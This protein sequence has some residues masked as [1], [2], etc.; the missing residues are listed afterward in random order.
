MEYAERQTFMKR[1]F[2][3]DC[4][5]S[6]CSAPYPQRLKSDH[7]IQTVAQLERCL[8]FYFSDFNTTDYAGG[9]IFAFTMFKKLKAEGACD[10]RFP[11]VY[12]TAFKM[13][14]KNGD[15]TRAKIFAERAY[16]ARVL[17]EGD[18]SPEAVRLAQ[19][20]QRPTLHPLYQPSADATEARLPREMSESKFEAW[21]WKQRPDPSEDGDSDE[22]AS[23][24]ESEDEYDD[25]P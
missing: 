5:C 9:L 3:F 6:L 7:R 16:A 22:F 12:H 13:A 25:D 21:L 11:G 2:G 19:F 17:V 20:V 14:V 4:G 18:D 10:A 23:E 24:F 15:T 8:V 1:H